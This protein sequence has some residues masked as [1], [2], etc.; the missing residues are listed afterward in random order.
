[1]TNLLVAATLSWPFAEYIKI[2]IGWV[3]IKISIIKCFKYNERQTVSS[4]P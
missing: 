2:T 4:H 3:F 1:M